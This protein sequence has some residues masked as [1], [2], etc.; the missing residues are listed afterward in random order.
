[1]HKALSRK[2]FRYRNHTQ[3]SRIVR[4]KKDGE[5]IDNVDNG[6]L[7]DQHPN[8]WAILAHK[9]YQDL[10]ESLRAILRLKK[11]PR[12]ELIY[13]DE[14]Y[15]RSVSSER[16]IVENYF[17]RMCSFW[18][19][20]SAKSMWS[21]SLYDVFFQIGISLTNAH[22][23]QATL[24]QEDSLK[25]T[26]IRNRLSHISNTITEKQHETVTR[27]QNRRRTEI[28]QRFRSVQDPPSMQ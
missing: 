11:P 17:R 21:H 7:H 12:G 4:N 1:M 13:A 18:S 16:I 26:R 3:K 20:L 23:N 25:F 5:D 19:L 24:R 22:V 27:Y 8:P 10:S 14:A 2:Y 28:K 6:L 15:N 9:G